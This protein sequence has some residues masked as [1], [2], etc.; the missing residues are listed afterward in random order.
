MARDKMNLK[1]QVVFVVV[2]WAC[3]PY[4]GFKEVPNTKLQ[5]SDAKIAQNINYLHHAFCFAISYI[6]KAATV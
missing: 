2:L 5:L 3:Y 6:S 4:R 1:T